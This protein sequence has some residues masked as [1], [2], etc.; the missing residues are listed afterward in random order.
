MSLLQPRFS[1]A[2]AALLAT[3]AIAAALFAPVAAA[4]TSEITASRGTSPQLRG[5]TLDGRAFDLMSLRGKVVMVVFWSTDCA[6]CRDKMPE[7]RANARGWAGQAFE[8]VSVSTDRQRGNALS[9]QQLVNLT[10]PASQRFTTLWT[11]EPGYRDSFGPTAT[12][13][14]A[15]LLDKNGQLVEQYQG[16]IPPE[17]WDR[18]ADLL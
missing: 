4:Q 13:P 6:V 2:F 16:R 12:L 18:I 11:G 15:F 3:L 8:L 5:S 7:L 14:A 10:V 1:A 9:Y 17:A